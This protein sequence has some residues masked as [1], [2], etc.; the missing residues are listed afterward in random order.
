MPIHQN[1]A[2]SCLKVINVNISMGASHPNGIDN[3]A[4]DLKKCTVWQGIRHIGCYATPLVTI[5]IRAARWPTAARRSTMPRHPEKFHQ[6]G[7]SPESSDEVP[8]F[9]TDR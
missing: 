9:D 3:P 6:N 5:S 7:V 1:K 8:Q 2:L 4:N